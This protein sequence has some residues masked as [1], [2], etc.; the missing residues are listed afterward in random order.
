ML[1]VWV[2][3]PDSGNLTAVMGASAVVGGG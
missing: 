2:T 3:S 1:K